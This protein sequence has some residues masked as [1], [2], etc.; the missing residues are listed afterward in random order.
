MEELIAI[1]RELIQAVHAGEKRQEVLDKLDSL[2][3]DITA[4]KSSDI[5][6]SSGLKGTKSGD[7]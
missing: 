6:S 7:S 4:Y 5:R 1:I 3:K 2:S